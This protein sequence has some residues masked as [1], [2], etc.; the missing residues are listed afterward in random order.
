MNPAP[1]VMIVAVAAGVVGIVSGSLSI[2]RHFNPEKRGRI[3][4]P[5]HQAEN[6]GRY[7]T[8]VGQV[9]SRRRHCAY[10]IAIQPS[11]CRGSGVWWPQ[12]QQLPLEPD[13]TWNLARGTLGR[14][15]ALGE[16]D[17]GKMYSL[18]L[19]E[20][21]MRSSM[22]ERFQKMS[23]IGERLTLSPSC[24]ILDSVEIRRVSY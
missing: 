19:I 17:I 8:A 5:T 22:Y 12:G 24:K 23:R 2:R 15:G 4:S 16:R 7:L 6:G 1:F 3:D 20:V 9:I 10:W 21:P 13:G 11:D 18:A 14:D